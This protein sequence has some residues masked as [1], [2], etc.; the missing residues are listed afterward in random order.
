M[1]GR[2]LLRDER[3]SVAVAGMLLTFA[4]ALLLG[5]CLDIA[6]AFILRAELTA[7]ADDAALAGAG[8]LDLAAWRQGRLA[9]DPGEA[10]QAARAELDASPGIAGEVSAGSAAVSVEVEQSFPTYALRLVGIPELRVVALARATP[11]TP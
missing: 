2:R 5:S 8:A 11:E 9:L 7:V 1:T 3:G 10:R 4:L 6:R